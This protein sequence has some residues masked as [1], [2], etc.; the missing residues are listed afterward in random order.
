M[1]IIVLE[2]NYLTCY[3]FSVTFLKMTGK[4]TFQVLVIMRLNV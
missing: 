4:L 3:S 2:Y 1:Y